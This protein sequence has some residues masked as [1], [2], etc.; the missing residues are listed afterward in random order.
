MLVEALRQDKSGLTPSISSVPP[1]I[2]APAFFASSAC[3]PSAKT[4]I[5]SSPFGF[6][7]RG[8]LTRPLGTAVPFPSSVLMESSYNVVG[9]ATSTA[10]ESPVQ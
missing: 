2:C 6:A 3:L 10:Y 4:R 1:T 8:R 7:S 9:E 5:L